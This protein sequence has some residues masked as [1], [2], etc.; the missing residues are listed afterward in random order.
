LLPLHTNRNQPHMKTL[1][2]YSATGAKVN[3]G[4][5]NRGFNDRRPITQAG[6]CRA[7]IDELI[8]HDLMGL[9]L[10]S[11]HFRRFLSHYAT[12]APPAQSKMIGRII[13]NIKK[14]NEISIYLLQTYQGLHIRESSIASRAKLHVALDQ[15]IMLYTRDVCTADIRSEESQLEP[16]KIEDE[17]RYRHACYIATV[18]RSEYA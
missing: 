12:Y 2:T 9:L 4:Q 5:T 18:G 7:I 10:S 1:S 16:A 17:R 11:S 8:D 15:K 13:L 14:V 3:D 6:L